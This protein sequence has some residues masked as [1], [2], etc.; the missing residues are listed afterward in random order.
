MESPACRALA[1]S[2]RC[3]SFAARGLWKQCRQPA[4]IQLLPRLI[5]AQGNCSPSVAENV[6]TR[7]IDDI[8]QLDTRRVCLLQQLV[9]E[10][11]MIRIA[12]GLGAIETP[13]RSSLKEAE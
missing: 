8:C 7:P 5:D 9:D 12:V 13:I 1:S 4:Q 6:L 3:K 10:A 11:A 2:L